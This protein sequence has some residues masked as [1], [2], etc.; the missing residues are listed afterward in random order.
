MTRLAILI[1]AG[2]LLL[3]MLACG[4]VP[5]CTSYECRTFGCALCEGTP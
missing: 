2:V 4:D 1:A 5:N 3:A